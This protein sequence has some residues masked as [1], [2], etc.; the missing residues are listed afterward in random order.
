MRIVQA[1]ASSQPPP[2]AKPLI[3][4]MTGLP[5][6]LDEI[7]HVLAAQGV[8]A[9]AAGVCSASSLMSAPATNDFSP[10]PVRITTRTAASW[11]QAEHRAAQLV[12]CLASSAR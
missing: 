2:R 12:E 10:A 6:L 4:A 11:R 9:A 8:V 1:I 3:A 7:E 5:E